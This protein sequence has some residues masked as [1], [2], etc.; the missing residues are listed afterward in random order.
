MK[1]DTNTDCALV[2]SNHADAAPRIPD[3]LKLTGVCDRHRLIEIKKATVYV[4]KRMDL[5]TVCEIELKTNGCDSR[6]VR[7]LSLKR[8]YAANEAARHD[9]SRRHSNR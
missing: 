7:R 5:R 4:C 2:G 1:P 6:A 3:K 9:R 8:L